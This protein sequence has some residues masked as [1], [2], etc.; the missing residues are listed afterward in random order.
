MNGV[1]R[2][3]REVS[4]GG[5]KAVLLDGRPVKTPLGARLAL[6]TPALA[7]AIAAEWSEQGEKLRPETMLLTKLANTAIDNVAADMQGARKQILA[8]AGSDLVCYRAEEPPE[9]VARQ[10]DAWDP[11]LDWLEQAHGAR[12]KTANGIVFVEQPAEAI[13]AIENAL[14]QYDAF[15]MA[16][17]LNAASLCGSAVLALA[18]AAERLDAEAAFAASQLDTI[19]QAERWGWDSEAEA[20]ARCA[21]EELVQTARFLRLLRL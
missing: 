20:K 2:F 15:A 13:L 6:P 10:K 7:E 21:Q 18:L 19:F 5:G 12:L 17:L 4:V 11:L 9:L 16:G 8:Y 1:R 14:A 3:Y